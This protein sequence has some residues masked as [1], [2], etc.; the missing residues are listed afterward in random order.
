MTMAERDEENQLMAAE[1]FVNKVTEL[2]NGR[3]ETEVSEMVEFGLA[4]GG[5]VIQY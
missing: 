4:D 3:A 1:V 2:T 5:K